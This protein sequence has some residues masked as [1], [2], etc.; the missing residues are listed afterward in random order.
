MDQK[1]VEMAKIE[2]RE[3]E[4]RKAQA[5][6]QFNDWIDKHPF[7]VS[8]RRDE[9]FLLCFLRLSKFNVDQA[10]QR[11]EK[12]FILPKKFPN[13]L[14]RTVQNIDKCLEL[15]DSGYF[16]PLPERDEDGRKVVVLNV[17][18][19]DVDK[20][21]AVEAIQCVSYVL[22]TLLEEPENQISG[23]SVILDHTDVQ[24]KHMFTPMDIKVVFET[25]KTSLSVRQKKLLVIHNSTFVAKIMEFCSL[26]ISD[27][28]KERIVLMKEVGE[29][30]D[31]VKPKSILPK[32]LGG[33]RTEADLITEFR[34]KMIE[35]RD[36]FAETLTFEVDWT[37][38]PKEKLEKDEF[39][40]IGSF[41]KLEI[42]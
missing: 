4:S 20:F 39:E 2:L 18:R 16:Y 22:T 7:I 6:Q 13:H 35:K 42:D 37:K 15:Y 12:F 36:V 11:Y 38:V 30:G 27:K 40:N 31:H 21:G 14:D 17:A 1:F 41:R 28:M 25:M 8:G 5:L 33:N 24:L 19:R 32:E 26:I 34:K 3:D 29:L 9:N 10:C 23:F